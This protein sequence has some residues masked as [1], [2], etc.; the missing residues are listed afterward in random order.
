MAITVYSQ[1]FQ[2]EIDIEQLLSL[3][4]HDFGLIKT[5]NKILS[6]LEKDEICQDVLCPICRSKGDGGKIVLA[7]TLQQ[8]H[9]KFD[10]H[11]Y[12]CDDN[13]SQQ[14]KG[15]KGRDVDFGK[16]RSNETKIIR[17]LV[18]KGIEQ[19]IISQQIISDMRKYFYEAKVKYQYKMDISIDALQW[20]YHL[21]CSKRK[22]LNISN[23]KLKFNPLHA[24]LPDFDWRL[25]AEIFF[26]NE[27]HNLIEMAN[28]CYWEDPPKT[29]NKIQKIIKN[30]QDS[31]VFD[32]KELEIPYRNTI[33]LSDFIVYNLA[34][35]NSQGWHLTN[36]N[37]VLAFAA[38]L[39]YISNWDIESAILK[40][41]NIV[42]SPNVTDRN[43][44]NVIGLNPFYDF[45]VW[46]SISKIR[47]VAKA[48]KKGFDYNAQIK[49]IEE[50]LK[51]ESKQ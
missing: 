1:R 22:S 41:I 38:L 25:A 27:N 18:T 48:S 37:I 43:S 36:S 39:L 16:D 2:R 42:K 26:I 34:I 30:T 32:V 35:K 23:I 6:K 50:Q 21:K 31:L 7:P 51:N 4:G 28:D 13:K 3:L 17:E 46:A 8:V 9:F 15:Q 19:K 49:T 10:V 14:K 24:Q 47:E 45:E 20:F 44:G 29:F 11:E 5:K 33:K 12:F 40:L